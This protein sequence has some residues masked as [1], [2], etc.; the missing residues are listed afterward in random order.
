VQRQH[1]VEQP[2]GGGTTKNKSIATPG[3]TRSEVIVRS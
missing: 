3:N 1:A 2:K